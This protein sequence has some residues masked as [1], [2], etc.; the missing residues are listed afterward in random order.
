M[1]EVI[2]NESTLRA[3]SVS[4]LSFSLKRTL[5]ETFAYVRVKGEVSGFKAHSSG[6]LYFSLKDE[7]AVINAICWRGI[8][9]NLPVQPEDGLEVI[10]TGNITTYPSGSR[11]QIVVNSIEASGQG[12]LLK[13]LEERKKKLALEGLFD[14]SRKK[15]LPFLPHIIG[16]I[17]SPTGA[18]IRDILH[19]LSDRMPTQVLLWPV[20]VQGQKASAE[21]ARAIRGF[22]SLSHKPDV[23]IVA[24]G[25]GSL[26]DLWAFNEE[27]VV[28][29]TAESHI[30]IISAVGHETDTTLI[31]YA[32][33]KRAPTPTG[34]AEMAVP[35]KADLLNML[36]NHQHRLHSSIHRKFNELSIKIE[37]LGRGIPHL[38]KIAQDYE[39]RLDDW[40]ER[41]CNASKQYIL[42]QQ[43]RTET[44]FR[45]LESF[46][47]QGVLK[48]GFTLVKNIKGELIP[49]KTDTKPGQIV[50]ITFQDGV[51]KALISGKK[52]SSASSQNP[53]ISKQMQLWD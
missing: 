16:V 7:K 51:Q 24:R 30:P 14:A 49:H 34:A 21:I 2:P 17:T 50:E 12:A 31:D 46:S 25:G 44:L 22:N 4:E 53:K 37:S 9:E 28:R 32:A 10:C 52:E 36:L 39:Q 6:H 20:A 42:S 27:E 18:V 8:A 47:Y 5:E 13:L 35:V 3:F 11:Y 1:N 26:E 38:S 40:S 48:R 43:S 33:D 23:L 29:A 15:P 41:F 19:R 45:L